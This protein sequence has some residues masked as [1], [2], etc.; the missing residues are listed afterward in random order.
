M[1]TAT[2]ELLL[3]VAESIA[4]GRPVDWDAVAA[5]ADAATL[6]RLREISA[7]A[8]QFSVVKGTIESKT[9]TA[10][11][12]QRVWAHLQLIEEIGRGS[13]GV[14]Y[15]AYDPLLR[16]AVALKLC[17]RDR[18]DQEGLLREA[19]L[20]AKVDHVGVLKIHGAALFEGPVAIARAVVT[21]QLCD[22]RCF[23]AGSDCSGY[24]LVATE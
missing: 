17:N 18:D 16:R 4:E 11:C 19:Q 15:R 9:R 22:R 6:A 24:I 8:G 3:R 7:L 5:G 21:Q 20:M 14:V 13:S 12:T 1:T 2:D 10:E 23:A